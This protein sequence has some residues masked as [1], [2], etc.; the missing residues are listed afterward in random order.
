M[1]NGLAQALVNA[2]AAPY[3]RSGRFPWHFARGKLSYDPIFL[4]ILARG[5]IPHGAHVLD[6]GCGQGLLSAWLGAARNAWKSL[7]WPSSWP[8]PP[9]LASYH[10]IE[11]RAQDVERARTSAL[12]GTF[13]CGDICTM[14]F[15]QA[16]VVTIFDVLHYIDQASQDSVLERVR[17]ILAPGGLL[18]LRVGDA[19]AG[20]RFRASQWL[21]LLMISA[22][23]RYWTR[24][25]C[26]PKEV[27]LER[28]ADLGFEVTVIPM[29][30]KT[31]FAN[32][33]LVA[34]RAK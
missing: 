10:G 32:V 17:E 23:G 27:W 6:L 5:L 14:P 4:A 19:A 16:D 1:S 7:S 33:L 13:A 20:W 3:R 8:E 22:R 25:H 29:S 30:E 24:L 2:A 12:M 28:L 15:V 31:P 9:R 34:R 18:L 21:D 11:R 26:R